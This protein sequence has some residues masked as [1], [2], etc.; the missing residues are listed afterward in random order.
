MREFKVFISLI[1]C[2]IFINTTSLRAEIS[3]SVEEDEFTD[4][5]TELIA[6]TKG[7]SVVIEESLE[8]VLYKNL[9]VGCL[10]NFC[11]IFLSNFY[12]DWNELGTNE[13]YVLLDGEKW[14]NHVIFQIETDI[15]ND[16]RE[17]YRFAYSK[18]YFKKIVEAKQFRSRVG[19]LIFSIDLTQLPLSKFSL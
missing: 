7:S 8:T 4:V 17:V 19:N 9:T 1:S 2:L 15:G 10:E 6:D 11:F 3:F 12:S 16:L 18:E 13:A 5:K 14:N